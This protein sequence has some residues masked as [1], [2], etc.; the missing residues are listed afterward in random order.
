MKL[1]QI[2]IQINKNNKKWEIKWNNKVTPKQKIM[3]KMNNKKIFLIQ[4]TYKYLNIRNQGIVIKIKKR[5]QYLKIV[6]TIT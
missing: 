6:K 1:F 5:K 2:F 3:F 4:E